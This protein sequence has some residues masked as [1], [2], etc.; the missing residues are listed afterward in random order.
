[1]S[2]PSPEPLDLDTPQGAGRYQELVDQGVR[3]CNTLKAQQVDLVKVQ[4]PGDPFVG[5]TDEEIWARGRFEGRG[6][7]VFYPWAHTLVHC[8]GEEDFITVR[9]S[10]NRDK[11]TAGEQATLRG[12]RIG[13]VGLSVGHSAAMTLALERVAGTFRLADFDT[14][15]LSNLN[16]IQTP[17]WNVG[18]NKC[19]V[20]ARDMWERDP[21]LAIDLFP[22]GAKEDT[23]EEFLVGQG[24]LDLVVEE[25]DSLEAKLAVRY[26]AR[27]HGIPV[28]MER[29]DQGLLDVERFDL[30]PHRPLLHGRVRECPVEDLG[31]LDEVQKKELF[32]QVARANHISPRMMASLGQV[33]KTLR[34]WPQLASAIALGGASVTEAARRILLSQPLES[35]EYFIDFDKVF[36]K[37]LPP[38]T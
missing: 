5:L 20:A 11:I 34:T 16:R 29:S 17:L 33:G 2:H 9:T 12:K 8:L 38:P 35:G 25:C 21:Y 37:S 30:E 24:R 13:V 4:N 3:V 32:F 7:A 23:L 31:R 14:I 22:R 26:A 18:L 19:E 36:E 28:V 10:R 15:D 1:M 6:F 27:K